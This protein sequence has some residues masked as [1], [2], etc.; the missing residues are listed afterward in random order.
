MLLTELQTGATTASDEF[1]ELYNAADAPVDI[2]GW[3]IRFVNA[4]NAKGTTTLLATIVPD[5]QLAAHAY[6]V[7][8]T[9]SITV[10][11]GVRHQSY[12]AVGK[13]SKTDKTVGLF[14]RRATDCTL[15]VEDAIAWGTATYGEGPAVGM[16]ADQTGK[17][18]LLQRKRQSAGLYRDTAHNNQDVLLQPLFTMASPGADNPIGDGGNAAGSPALLVP[19]T[20]ACP[21]SPSPASPP[22]VLSS[23][24]APDLATPQ[25]SE[26][27]PDPASPQTDA[28]DEFIEL[29]NPNDEPFDLAGFVLEAGG[30]TPKRY[31]FPAPTLM[32]PLSFVAFGITTTKVGLANSGGQ[33]KLLDPQ[34]MPAGQSDPYEDAVAGS[35]WT[36]IDERWQ[37]TIQPT[38]NA[39]NV[40]RRQ[41]VV[42][43]KATTV[44]ARK[45]VK[46]RTATAKTTKKIT[47]AP[48]TVTE[49]AAVA[50]A[51][52][53]R[54]VHGGV[55][56]VVGVLAVLYGAYEYRTDLANK[57]RQYRANRAARRAAGQKPEGR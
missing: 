46:G 53:T 39:I 19:L 52:E 24:S 35:A 56:A 16:P 40:A 9:D 5:M 33:V 54:T 8:H 32:P 57:I 28:K 36:Y 27:L 15:T 49:H 3:Q 11:P 20:P 44:P 10:A 25:L 21:S 51:Q 6:Y 7:L 26:L 23:P 2:G 18:K 41:E 13:L 12:G 55:L 43:K 4:T 14:G 22:P 1:I 17:E 29:Y 47:E 50:A 37:W 45:A 38:P 34:G 42:P 30:T 48:P 31:V